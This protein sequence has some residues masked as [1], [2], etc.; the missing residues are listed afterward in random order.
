[1]HN[2]ALYYSLR[3]DYLNPFL[4]TCPIHYDE[5]DVFYATSFLTF[6]YI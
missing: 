6:Q 4:Q 3:E 2:T 5:T 1:M